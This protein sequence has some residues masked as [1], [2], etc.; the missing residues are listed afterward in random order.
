[1]FIMAATF[2]T[3]GKYSEYRQCSLIHVSLCP[4]VIEC[5]CL[6]ICE[7]ADSERLTYCKTL[8]PKTLDF[9]CVLKGWD[10]QLT[11]DI[12]HERLV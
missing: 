9:F 4:H 6:C 3:F 8:N 7:L 5:H 2:L 12:V 11:A 1:M 10:T